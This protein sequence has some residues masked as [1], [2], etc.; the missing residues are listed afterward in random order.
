MCKRLVRQI[1]RLVHFNS[2]SEICV[3]DIGRYRASDATSSTSSGGLTQDKIETRMRPVESVC[4]C[5]VKC[6]TDMIHLISVLVSD[7]VH[8][9][10]MDPDLQ[11]T[12]IMMH[13]SK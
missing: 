4:F 5:W 2:G 7:V 8:C 12:R 13:E 1:S 10:M 6:K 9:R 11:E 3:D